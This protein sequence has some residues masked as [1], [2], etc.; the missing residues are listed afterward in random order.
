MRYVRGLRAESGHAIEAERRCRPFADVA[1][2]TAR[3]ALRRN[4]LDA[5]A[6][7]GALAGL[8]PDGGSRRSAL[9]Q[10]AA[11]ERDRGSLFAGVAPA[12][13]AS[14]LTEMTPLETTLADYRA[15]GLTTGPQVMTHLRAGL[16]RRGVLATGELRSAHD[17][18]FVRVAGHV[19]V[20]QRPVSAK[21]F[22]FLTLE[23]ETGTANAVLTP[24]Q[25]QRFRARLHLSPL[26]EI[27]GPL[28]SEEGVIHVRVRE[29]RPIPLPESL[30][31]SHDYR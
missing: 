30:P 1:D 7:A 27:A 23:D 31:R 11:V 18:R 22:C 12:A 5:L 9:W 16:R 29:L 14:P 3:V 28:Q 20:R 2:L 17:G 19:I 26:L 13:G 6:E 24:R 4:E 21:G 15:S 10:V 25:F 8:D